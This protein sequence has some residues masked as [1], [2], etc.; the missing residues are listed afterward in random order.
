MRRR[1]VIIILSIV[2]VLAVAGCSSS[3]IQDNDNVDFPS[4]FYNGGQP[5]T[6][7]EYSVTIGSHSYSIVHNGDRDNAITNE[8]RYAAYVPNST[9]VSEDEHVVTIVRDH[10]EGLATLTDTF[11]ISGEADDVLTISLTGVS[12]ELN[13]TVYKSI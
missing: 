4:L 10:P 9:A 7:S 12:P 2:A 13:I 3:G 6:N 5:W 11:T 8:S 1:A